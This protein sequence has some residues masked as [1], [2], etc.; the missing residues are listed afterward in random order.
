MNIKQMVKG[1]NHVC[2]AHIP[3]LDE[4][5]MYF[6]E[7][8]LNE[9]NTYNGETISSYLSII[10]SDMSGNSIYLICQDKHT[11]HSS[12]AKLCKLLLLSNMEDVYEY[13]DNVLPNKGVDVF[14]ADDDNFFVKSANLLI[15]ADGVVYDCEV[16]D[17]THFRF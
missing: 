13:M 14:I 9:D 1:T 2:D 5:L 11:L 16:V 17:S 6:D 7:S 15:T 10:D 3:K 4:M 8:E 12:F